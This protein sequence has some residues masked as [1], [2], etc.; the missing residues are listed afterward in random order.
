MNTNTF[1][2]TALSL[3]NGHDTADLVA[4]LAWTSQAVT[5][6]LDCVARHAI[7]DFPAYDSQEQRLERVAAASPPARFPGLT[8][9]KPGGRRDKKKKLKGKKKKKTG[10]RRHRDCRRAIVRPGPPR[11]L[12]LRGML[13]FEKD[14]ACMLVAGPCI[15]QKHIRG[16][17][18]AIF[19]VS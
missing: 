1:V 3:A 16:P 17:I 11:G 19:R 10:R 2:T 15:Y 5:V 6:Q 18:R 13:K 8:T 12:I 14:Y 4:L 7:A 9:T